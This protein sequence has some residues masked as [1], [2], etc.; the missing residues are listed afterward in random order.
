MTIFQLVLLIAVMTLALYGVGLVFDRAF[1]PRPHTI[2]R[3]ER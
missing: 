2:D 1:R 3:G